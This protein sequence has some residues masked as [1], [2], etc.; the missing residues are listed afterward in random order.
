MKIIR[1]LTAACLALLVAQSGAFA[2]KLY[3]A[4]YDRLPGNLGPPPPLAQEPAVANQTVD[5]SGGATSS[6]V[7]GSTTRY[8]RLICDVQCSLKFGAAPAA[9]NA[10]T[11]MPALTPEYFGVQPGH[12]ISVIANP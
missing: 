11:P 9:T 4:E 3:I 12:R 1:I 5:F 10:N 2:A 8:V 6:A 7:F